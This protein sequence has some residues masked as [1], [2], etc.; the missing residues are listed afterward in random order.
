MSVVDRLSPEESIVL[1]T[2]E[3]E[4]LS[5]RNPRLVS[6]P[7]GELDST[8]STGVRATDVTADSVS[9]KE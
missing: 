5:S 8:S 3:S 7:V 2:K 9:D 1:A 6:V 4:L